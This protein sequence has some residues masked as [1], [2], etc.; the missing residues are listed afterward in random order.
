MRNGVRRHVTEL[1]GGRRSEKLWTY[2]RR[3]LVALAQLELDGSSHMVLRG[4]CARG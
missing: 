4:H 1:G 3:D 2:W